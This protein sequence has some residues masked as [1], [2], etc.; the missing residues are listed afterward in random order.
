MRSALVVLGVLLAAAS[1]ASTAPA[2]AQREPEPRRPRLAPDADTNSAA[3]Y[4]FLGTAI[5]EKDPAKAAEA[6]YWASRLDPTWAD[7][8][9]AR[10]IALHMR[11]R[12]HL[13]RYVGGDPAT[14][15]DPETRR[16]D[17][18][19]LRARLR[20]PFLYTRLERVMIQ[21]ASDEVRRTAT[22]QLHARVGNYPRA[23]WLAYTEGDFDRA[24]E[25]YA[26]AIAQTPAAYGLHAARA[27][28]FYQ[29]A[30]Y[31]SALAEQRQLL[32]KSRKATAE[33]LAYVYD[34]KAM[35]EYGLGRIHEAREDL[36]AAK[37]A[38]GR[39]LAEDLSFYM[40][41]AAL[42]DVHLAQGDTAGA[43][44]EYDLAVQL[45]GDDA[46][47]RTSF[48]FILAAAGRTDAAI[49]HLRRAIELE[50]H[51]APPYFYLGRMLERKGSNEALDQY[52]R[53]VARAR[54]DDER[55]PVA[56]KILEE[57]G[58]VAAKPE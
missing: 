28:V 49:P 48:G 58:R 6:F 24:L 31:D 1:A 20:N 13:I 46:A 47:L 52:E 50:P 26:R 37:E 56:A 43:I 57:F 4:H 21:R 8:L 40:A 34:S 22:K 25:Y 53:F 30:L 5:L 23:A 7:P 10:R 32:D 19:M 2:R 18:L 3:A 38:Y 36:P 55:I 44:E 45:R 42:G 14:L 17:S 27:R 29:L 16:I 33:R 51:F 39:A 11:D 12:R 9:Y 15:L 41:H 35:Y 54:R